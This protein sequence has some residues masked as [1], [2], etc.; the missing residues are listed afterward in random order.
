VTLCPGCAALA[1]VQWCD[2]IDSADGGVEQAMVVCA[3]RQ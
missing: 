1:E 2:V 3:G